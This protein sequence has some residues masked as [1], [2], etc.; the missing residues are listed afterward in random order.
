MKKVTLKDIADVVGMSTMTVSK[1]LNDKSDISIE[2]KNKIIQT[3]QQ[4]GYH[5]DQKSQT[6]FGLNFVCIITDRFFFETDQFYPVIYQAISRKCYEYNCNLSLELVHVDMENQ[7]L[8]PE[9]I[10][11][12][13]ANGIFMLG[14]VSSKY[15]EKVLSHAVP[16]I[17]VDFYDPLFPEI[18]S[19]LT[20]NQTA[21]YNITKY[22]VSLGH[23]HLAFIGDLKF[24]SSIKDR[25]NGFLKALEDYK[26][27]TEPC[28]LET[29]DELPSLS[30]KM[31]TGIFTTS[32]GI[33]TKAVKTLLSLGYKIPEQIS[34]TGFDNIPMSKLGPKELTTVDID[35]TRMGTVSFDTLYNMLMKNIKPSTVLLDTE[36]IVRDSTWIVNM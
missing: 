28:L 26:I 22:L 12:K 14:Q 11:S 29:A 24:S 9:S 7:L 30:H 6:S 31:P 35:K 21:A 23:T 34:I 17:C 3:A 20:D 32:D 10:L 18:C 13:N 16:T 19:I 1:A 8:I 36:I 5:K 27:Q 15:L 33:A 25:Y 2:V 4:M